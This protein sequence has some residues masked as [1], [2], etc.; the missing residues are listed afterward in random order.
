M[1]GNNGV[2]DTVL[3]KV[4]GKGKG[5]TLCFKEEALADVGY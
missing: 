4:A 1:S 3:S 2:A 5:E